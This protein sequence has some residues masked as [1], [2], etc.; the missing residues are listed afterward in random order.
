MAKNDLLGLQ[1]FAQVLKGPNIGNMYALTQLKQRQQAQEAEL[2]QKR[3]KQEMDD[4]EAQ[5]KLKDNPN[6]NLKLNQVNQETTQLAKN[7]FSQVYNQGVRQGQFTPEGRQMVAGAKDAVER[8]QELTQGYYTTNQAILGEIDKQ[9]DV[10]KL[11]V[12]KNKL[13]SL[14]DEFATK[15]A[16]GNW[17]LDTRVI[18]KQQDFFKDPTLYDPLKMVKEYSK[19]I[20]TV[21]ND[22]FRSGDVSDQL[23]FKNVFITNDNGEPVLDKQT[24]KPLV[25][26]TPEAIALFDAGGEMNAKVLDQYAAEKG[27]TRDK[28]FGELMGKVADY[29][30]VKSK[31]YAS[32]EGAARP[33]VDFA[34]SD[35]KGDSFKPADEVKDG[36]TGVTGKEVDLQQGLT[37]EQRKIRVTT[38]QGNEQEV[39]VQRFGVSPEGEKGIWATPL[40]VDGTLQEKSIFLPISK[41]GKDTNLMAIMNAKLKPE[42]R[43]KLND[44][45]KQFQASKVEKTVMDDEKLD[46]VVSDFDTTLKGYFRGDKDAKNI[47]ASLVEMGL[48]SGVEVSIA[49]G[50]INDVIKI[51]DEE[52]SINK[53]TPMTDNAKAK[54]KETIYNQAPAKFSKK[55]SDVKAAKVVVSK[56]DD[57]DKWVPENEYKVGD[58][59]YFYDKKSG[60]WS[61]R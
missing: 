58:K 29:S 2:A 59:T 15:D 48:P 57:V 56:G 10:M 16:N 17:N 60:E 7:V 26:T 52:I 54:I 3:Q 55:A 53:W 8:S 25:D 44:V 42:E 33:V 39:E 35:S 12:A 40:N 27:M 1:G 5:I 24:G 20:G 46:K 50:P 30:S 51:G 41:D 18:A 31:H 61:K 22:V 9:K 34:L 28:A 36:I 38:A 32:G 45:Y 21:A 13:K 19:S 11:D 6:L 37:K 49:S 43:R 14:D 4:F 47:K 23:K